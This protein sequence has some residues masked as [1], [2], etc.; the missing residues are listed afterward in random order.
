[1][2]N[3]S[4]TSS[5]KEE[6]R[7]VGFHGVD[8]EEETKI[9]TD[10]GKLKPNH[11]DLLK[12][13]LNNLKPCPHC[14]INESIVDLYLQDTTSFWI[15]GCGRCGCHSGISKDKYKVVTSW[16][17][18]AP[19]KTIQRDLSEEARDIGL[20]P[21]EVTYRDLIMNCLNLLE[22]FGNDD[23]LYETPRGTGGQD[24]YVGCPTGMRKADQMVELIKWVVHHKEND[25]DNTI[26]SEIISKNKGIIECEGKLK[27]LSED[28]EIN[29]ITKTEMYQ[30]LLKE[31]EELKKTLDKK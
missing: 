14:G 11:A 13:S 27:G 28:K 5:K 12:E 23:D 4:G 17:K 30:K 22:R 15:I 25:T 20:K 19:Q 18:R 16:N 31:N 21:D 10:S 7:E 26:E 1:M 3:N 29:D 8:E 2:K 24:G 6:I 9:L